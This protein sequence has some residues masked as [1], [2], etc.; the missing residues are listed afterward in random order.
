MIAREGAERA[1]ALRAEHPADPIDEQRLNNLGYSYLAERAFETAIGIF[2]LNASAH[3]Q[4]A[5]AMDSLAEALLKAGRTTEAM[6]SYERVLKL[7]E[8]DPSL[9]PEQKSALERNA[10]EMLRQRKD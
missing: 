5:N 6:E 4:S 7:I 8:S 10:R 2:R 3:P 9:K 1:L